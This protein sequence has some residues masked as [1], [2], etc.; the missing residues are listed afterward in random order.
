MAPPVSRH[1]PDSPFARRGLAMFQ[2][3]RSAE[4]FA[5]EIKSHLELEA[6]ELRDSGLSEEEAHRRARSAFGSVAVA[7]ERF[8]LRARW[9]WWDN[10]RRD[11]RFGMRTLITSPGFS[12]TAVITLA[13]GIG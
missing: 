12:L 10:L 7:Q 2:R 9:A 8:F 3:K 11:L 5:E 4:D 1:G 13:L 6:G